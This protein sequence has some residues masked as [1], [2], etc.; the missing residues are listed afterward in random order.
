MGSLRGIPDRL[1][2]ARYVFLNNF[3]FYLIIRR[4]D[5]AEFSTVLRF[6]RHA[7]PFASVLDPRVAAVTLKVSL[8]TSLTMYEDTAMSLMD[9]WIEYVRRS[10]AKD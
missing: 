5:S 9:K 8:S 6:F 10:Q 7:R 4:R 1:V 3:C 2:L